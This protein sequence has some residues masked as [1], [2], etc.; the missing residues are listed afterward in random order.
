M[1]KFIINIANYVSYVRSELH[2]L[3]VWEL[4]N[5]FSSNANTDTFVFNLSIYVKNPQTWHNC[6][7]RVF[8]IC[9]HVFFTLEARTGQATCV[10][11]TS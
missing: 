4:M 3:L 1:P 6:L 11:N 5:M 10:Y 9:R 7:S 2:C 8:C